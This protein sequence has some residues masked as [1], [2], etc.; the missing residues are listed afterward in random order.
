MVLFS[1]ALSRVLTFALLPF[2]AIVGGCNLIDTISI[3]A[4]ANID[5]HPAVSH[6]DLRQNR[7]AKTR[8]YSIIFVIV[9]PPHEKDFGMFGGFGGGFVDL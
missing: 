9:Q 4:I 3:H 5:I 2:F 7:L 8:F 1:N 6:I